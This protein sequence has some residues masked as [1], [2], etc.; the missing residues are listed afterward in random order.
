M[1][2]TACPRSLVHLYI[3]RLLRELDHT[4][5]TYDT[6]YNI[7]VYCCLYFFLLCSNTWCFYYMYKKSCQVF[8]VCSLYIMYKTSWTYSIEMF[9]SVK[10]KLKTSDVILPISIREAA[11][12]IDIFLGLATKKKNFFWSSKIKIPDFFFVA[13][14]LEGGG[15]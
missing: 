6:L 10:V 11:T 8:M 9:G 14:K 13:T 4:S 5:L 1:T 7:N 2:D 15:R 12:K 3:V